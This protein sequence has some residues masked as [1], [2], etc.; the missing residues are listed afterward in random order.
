[1]C[2]FSFHV[3]NLRT[4][5]IHTLCSSSILKDKGVQW[6]CI[7]GLLNNV[8]KHLGEHKQILYE[9]TRV[10]FFRPPWKFLNSAPGTCVCH[11]TGGVTGTVSHTL[12]SLDVLD[13]TGA[14][15]AVSDDSLPNITFCADL[16]FESIDFVCP[17]K[18]WLHWAQYLITPVMLMAERK[19]NTS[20]TAQDEAKFWNKYREEIKWFFFFY[21]D[22]IRFDVAIELKTR[23]QR[24][25][26]CAHVQQRKNQKMSRWPYCPLWDLFQTTI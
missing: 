17:S 1:M 6:T 15:V 21:T 11:I 5:K 10:P 25:L 8:W 23:S 14:V 12:S 22:K 20:F 7:C 19:K 13:P 16:P 2:I 3:A 24:R 18:T 4:E 9:L 26:L